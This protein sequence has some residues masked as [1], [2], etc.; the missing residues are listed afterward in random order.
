[1]GDYFELSVWTQCKHKGPYQREAGGQSEEGV[2]TRTVVVL[3]ERELE[4]LHCWHEK[5]GRAH[6]PRVP[7]KQQLLEARKGKGT[8][9]AL[10]SP[11]WR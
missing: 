10:K 8:D 5:R 6:K 3:R 11:E 4:M 7:L 9:Y 1:M 2:M